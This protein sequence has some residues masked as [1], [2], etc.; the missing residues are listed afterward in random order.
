MEDINSTPSNQRTLSAAPSQPTPAA[1]PCLPEIL[2]SAFDN[3]LIEAAYRSGAFPRD[4]LA[5]EAA[6]QLHPEREMDRMWQQNF[7]N[8]V[9]PTLRNEEGLVTVVR[10]WM[11]GQGEL[12]AYVWDAGVKP[13]RSKRVKRKVTDLEEGEA[14][15]SVSKSGVPPIQKDDKEGRDSSDEVA[16]E[17]VTSIPI[18]LI[19]KLKPQ[20]TLNDGLASTKQKVDIGAA[21]PSKSKGKGKERAVEKPAQTVSRKGE[22][23]VDKKPNQ[24]LSR[25]G[26]EKMVEGLDQGPSKRRK[27]E[28]VQKTLPST[29]PKKQRGSPSSAQTKAADPAT[30]A[31]TSIVTPLNSEGLPVTQDTMEASRGRTSKDEMVISSAYGVSVRYTISDAVNARK[32]GFTAEQQKSLAD[33]GMTVVAGHCRKP[34]HEWTLSDGEKWKEPIPLPEHRDKPQRDL[35]TVGAQARGLASPTLKE[36]RAL[37]RGMEEMNKKQQSGTRSGK[38]YLKGKP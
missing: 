6:A 22:E 5:H 13:S 21:G 19:I 25:K 3:A 11:A 9:L 8:A 20:E 15:S 4:V 37:R 31:S 36:L 10:R 17:K 24:S 7:R 18:R 30:C 29:P 35:T 32:A 28:P 26:K 1:T 38:R 16:E 2:S 14:S 27:A 33:F 34:F 23:E 12:G